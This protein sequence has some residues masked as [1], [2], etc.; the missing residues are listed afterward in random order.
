MLELVLYNKL[1]KI[2]QNTKRGGIFIDK[3]NQI[4]FQLKTK[5]I[6]SKIE[7]ISPRNK[8]YFHTKF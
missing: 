4:L 3:E 5:L 2:V 8:I 1:L 6:G 7:P